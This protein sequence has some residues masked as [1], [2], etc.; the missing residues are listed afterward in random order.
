MADWLLQSCP[1]VTSAVGWFLNY[2]SLQHPRLPPKGLT[3]TRMLFPACQNLGPVLPLRTVSLRHIPGSTLDQ[4]CYFRK[5]SKEICSCSALGEWS[6]VL[7]LWKFLLPRT[8][9][10]FTKSQFRRTETHP[11]ERALCPHILSFCSVPMALGVWNWSISLIRLE[12]YKAQNS[13]P[14]RTALNRFHFSCPP[15]STSSP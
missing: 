14:T 9:A 1:T 15:D 11:E 4:V 5:V 10:K 7:A 6:L 12:E 3:E 8:M 2:C 13:H